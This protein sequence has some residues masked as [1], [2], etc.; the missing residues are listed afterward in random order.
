MLYGICQSV[1]TGSRELWERAWRCNVGRHKGSVI[2][3]FEF[4][5]QG[6]PLLTPG[7]QR[8]FFSYRAL[9]LVNAASP[10]TISI[11]K[12]KISSG[13]QGNLY[14]EETQKYLWNVIVLREISQ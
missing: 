5:L 13:T 10:R 8:I 9:R 2:A 11:D 7:F 12:K 4:T 14:C 6:R 3:C 1:G